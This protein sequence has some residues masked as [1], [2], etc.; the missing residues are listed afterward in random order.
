MHKTKSHFLYSLFGE[1]SLDEELTVP[2]G[3]K[4]EARKNVSKYL[5]G[6]YTGKGQEQTRSVL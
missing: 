3:L 4:G 2:H 1:E 6:F 5:K